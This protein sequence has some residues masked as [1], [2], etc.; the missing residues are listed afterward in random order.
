MQAPAGNVAEVWWQRPKVWALLAVGVLG[1]IY[2]ASM[3]TTGLWDPWETHYGEVARQMLVRHDPVDT[4]WK[5]GNA[6]PDG[7]YENT[8][9]SKP[10]LP[11]WLMALSMKIFGVGVSADPAEM[12]SG[13]W[14]ELA[15]RLPSMIAGLGS[16]AF[17]GW[18]LWRLVSPRAGVLAA[19]A[20]A[21]MPQWAIVTRQALT[22]MFFVGPV[23]IAAGAWAMAWL[24]PDRDLRRRGRGRVLVPWDRAYLVFVVAFV[25]TVIV[26]LAVIHQHSYDPLTWA[27]VGKTKKFADGLRDIQAHM[28]IYWALV[29]VVFVR[30]LTWKRRSQAWMGIL[31]LAGGVSLVGKGMIGPGLIG[32][33]VLVHLIVSK[34]WRLLLVCGLPTG[35]LL[36]ALA[37]FPWHHA[38][39]LYRGEKFFSELI[40]VNNL[41]R[42]STGEQK[43]AVGGFAYYLETMGL[44]A[45]PWAAVM[46]LALWAGARAFVEGPPTETPADDEEG[47]REPQESDDPRRAMY[48]FA[49]L[50]ALASLFALSYSATKYYHYLLP[51]LPPLAALIGIWLDDALAGRRAVS[52]VGVG[53]AAVIGIAVIVGVL[54]DLEANPAWLAHLTTYLYTG[55]WTKGGPDVTLAWWACGPFALGLVAWILARHRVAVAAFIFSATLSTAWVIDD[56]L[57]AASENWSQRSMMRVYFDNRTKNDRMLSWWFYY[58]GE[59]LMTKGDLWVM[60]DHHPKK[61]REYIV[62]YAAEHEGQGAAVWIATITPHAKRLRGHLPTN[63]RPGYELMYESFHYTLVRVSLP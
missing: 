34:R 40:V 53:V 5:G 26:P 61:L 20:L 58:R 44:G 12:V 27:R 51:C 8:F 13:F 42:F 25:L 62:E 31:Y 43:Q 47:A 56:Y 1:T 3:S 4:Y 15:L 30:S 60:K 10:A 46:P 17:L 14:P 38:M 19:V 36:F 39:L 41:Q 9:W 63:L 35:I 24:Q 57:P 2:F 16:A 23:V 33:I 18:V 54:R 50:W 49:L 32:L 7:N 37:G 48:Q 45:L 6:G 21:T 55:M 22:D 11:F 29:G 59:T 28:F 52:R